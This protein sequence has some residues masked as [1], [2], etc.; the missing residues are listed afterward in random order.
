VRLT[1]TIG[2]GLAAL[3]LAGSTSGT[4]LARSEA[5]RAI[6]VTQ[7]GAASAAR[8]ILVVGCIHGNEP[9]GISVARR[10]AAL[11]PPNGVAVWIASDANPDGVAAGTRGNADGVDLNRNF[12]W[13]WRPLGG[14]FDSGPQPLSEPESEALARLVQRVR[15]TIA[16]W[17]HQHLGGV[18]ES[19]GSVS[20]ERRYARLVGLPLLRLTRYPGSAV[21]WE[22]HILPRGTA[23]VVELPAGALT[24][25]E[26]DRYARSILRLA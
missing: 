6:V 11:H 15:P 5:G 17:F 19:G 3:V 7:L 10:L 8:R 18:D 14:S 23:F 1:V 26:A 16:L 21:G 2:A 9:A 25:P 4:V 24:A 12:P 20:V 13:R 22:N